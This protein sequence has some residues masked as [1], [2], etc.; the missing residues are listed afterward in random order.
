[1]HGA[2]GIVQGLRRRLVGQPVCQRLLVFRCQR[3]RVDEGGRA[4]RDSAAVR[5]GGSVAAGL[6][7]GRGRFGQRESVDV[8]GSPAPGAADREPD[9]AA[10]GV[11]RQPA[12]QLRRTRAA[13]ADVEPGL[14]RGRGPGGELPDDPVRESRIQPVAQHAEL[15]RVEQLVDLVPAPRHGNQVRRPGIERNAPGQLG[16]LA[17]A[18]HITQVLPQVVAGPALDLVDLV[19]QGGQGAVFGDP[20]RRG[21]LPHAGDARQVIARVAAQ[22]GVVRVL[23]RGQAVLLVHRRRGEPGH[24]AD[25]AP[26]HQNRDIVAYQLECVPVA[27][28]NQDLHAARGRLRGERGDDIVGLVPGDR[29]P[30]DPER[31]QYL[32]DQAELTLE[33]RRGLPAVGLVLDVLLVPECRLAAVEGDSDVAGLLVAQYVDQHRREP[34]HGIGRLT[35]RRR[36]VLRW[37]G[38]ERPVGER[39]P[40]EQEEE[41]VPRRVVCRRGRVHGSHPVILGCDVRRAG[42]CGELGGSGGDGGQFGPA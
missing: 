30:R 37:Q 10:P 15:Q 8:P 42:V 28:D 23:S 11:P 27:G 26:G 33:V 1:M 36:E 13:Q 16:E 22:C 2:L 6:I 18:Q 32:E 20:L 21:L 24:V 34:V 19:D 12:G 5:P 25:A 40:V 38:E 4:G 35:R 7:A 17:V 31:V 29:Q 3:R 14:R 9:P 41:F 39:V